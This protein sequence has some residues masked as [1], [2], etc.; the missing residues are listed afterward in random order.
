MAADGIRSR[1]G[2]AVAS[3]LKYFN[4]LLIF[5]ETNFMEVP[6]L[7]KIYGPRKTGAL[8]YMVSFL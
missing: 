3:F 7:C 1:L 6:K 8:R 5:G 4:T 2:K